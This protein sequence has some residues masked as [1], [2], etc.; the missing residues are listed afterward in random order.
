MLF[1]LKF[2]QFHDNL[3]QYILISHIN[4]YF[5]F[6][7]LSPKRSFT[8][9]LKKY[10]HYLCISCIN[11]LLDSLG[12]PFLRIRVLIFVA[13]NVWNYKQKKTL[14]T[15]NICSM[16]CYEMFFIS[17]CHSRI[18]EYEI[19]SQLSVAA[20]H[21]SW[22]EILIYVLVVAFTLTC[23][24]NVHVYHLRKLHFHN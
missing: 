15:K 9:N 2:K 22:R 18:S 19:L 1:F 4:L 20:V 21:I 11:K 6:Q 3:I 14:L 12:L 17:L 8:T 5:K 7:K 24:Y 23:I 13:L 10:E 16:A